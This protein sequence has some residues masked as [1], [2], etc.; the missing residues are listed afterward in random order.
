MTPALVRLH[1]RRLGAVAPLHP[2]GGAEG[3]LGL[4][5]DPLPRS[6]PRQDVSPG[7]LP[8]LA[9]EG[10]ELGQADAFPPR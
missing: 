4:P 10:P 5:P 8:A 3:G 9:K 1:R 2:A 6:S 7:A